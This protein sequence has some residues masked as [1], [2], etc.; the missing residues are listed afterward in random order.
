[1]KKKFSIVVSLCLC[2][3]LFAQST[4]NPGGGGGTSYVI[5]PSGGSSGAIT[6]SQANGGLNASG[7]TVWFGDN[8]WRT[9]AG[10]GDAVVGANNAFTLTNTFSVGPIVTPW[11][12]NRLILGGGTGVSTPLAAGTSNQV[13]HSAGSGNAPVF[14]AVDLA[15]ATSVSGNL[16][17]SNLNSGTSSGLTTFWNGSGIWSTPTNIVPSAHATSHKSGGTDA[18]K[19]DELAATT[20][21]TT[22]NATTSAHGLLPKL[23]NVATEYL[24]GTGAWSVPAGGGSGGGDVFQASNN[25]FTARQNIAGNSTLVVG[26]NASMSAY[27][28]FSMV[29]VGSRIDGRSLLAYPGQG[30][31][32]MATIMLG[33]DSNR[34]YSSGAG[35]TG[36]NAVI[37]LD[38][39]A[40][41]ID[42]PNSG[43]IQLQKG[44]SG[45]SLK[46]E[47][48]KITIAGGGD[49]QL[50]GG[51]G[52]VIIGR[53]DLPQF[54]TQW[55]PAN[56]NGSTTNYTT[57]V[58]IAGGASSPVMGQLVTNGAYRSTI[59]L[60][61]IL[62]PAVATDSAG[63]A[64][65]VI[66]STGTNFYGHSLIGPGVA[67][68]N[69]VNI[70]FN[71]GNGQMWWPTNLGTTGSAT[72]TVD[73]NSFV[74]W[75]Q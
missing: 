32:S 74:R 12:L 40:L 16:S 44:N 35:Y 34:V 57:Y 67:V 59:S 30:V 15:N 66:N 18:I 53:S 3:T 6:P 28:N 43:Y 17:V 14:K 52:R 23:S 39:G 50:Y 21:V 73:T 4:A 71:V 61:F 24:N 72:A 26:T 56:T 37:A 1:M 36:E 9:P 13:L 75:A 46:I 48:G 49:L 63:A 5:Q 29:S 65:A 38:A 60:S 25:V 10:S 45:T 47:S 42:P 41:F 69:K 70:T 54:L 62:T 11:T 33:A 7:T 22:L 8:T 58:P 55:F 19:L 31:S 51:G 64:V 2:A 68:A 20:D 27:T